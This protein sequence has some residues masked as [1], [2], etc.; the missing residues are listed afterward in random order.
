MRRFVHL[1]IVAALGPAGTGCLGG[2]GDELDGAWTLRNVSNRDCSVVMEFGAGEFEQGLYCGLSD[3]SVG[4][5]LSRGRYRVVG[6]TITFTPTHATC[7]D[8]DR[9]GLTTPF[10]IEDD[11]LTLDLPRGRFA[12]RRGKPAMPGAAIHGCFGDMFTFTES[13]LRVLE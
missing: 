1:A 2:A 6:N 12:L 11:I 13:M 3:G 7:F 4:L 10:T 9:A 5:D 8:I